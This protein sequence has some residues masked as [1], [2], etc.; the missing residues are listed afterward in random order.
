MN[1]IE[2]SGLESEAQDEGAPEPQ[3]TPAQVVLAGVLGLASAGTGSVAVFETENE[4]GSAA[5]LA[6]GVYFLLAAVLRRFPKLKFGDTEIDPT[7]RRLARQANQ[8]SLQAAEDAIDAKEGLKAATAGTELVAPEERDVAEQMD[9]RIAELAADYNQVRYTMPSGAARTRRME[10]IVESMIDRFQVLGPPDV[11]AL[12]KSR[13]RGLR[14]AAIA[15]AYAWPNGGQVPALVEA[16]VTPD[17]PFNE[18]WALKA[19]AKSLDADPRSLSSEDRQ[20]LLDRLRTLPSGA[21]RAQVLRSILG[22]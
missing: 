21:D 20:R 4:V 1:N 10:N 11:Q 3:L 19:L 5:L 13:D 22:V 16:A 12:V 2:G 18:Y 8:R 17:K 15:A 14:L 6:I 9:P 7:A